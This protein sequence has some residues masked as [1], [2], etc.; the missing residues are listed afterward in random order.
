MSV[1]P[2]PS[3]SIGNA[4]RQMN[5]KRPGWLR[6]GLSAA[7]VL[8]T[9]LGIHN[10]GGTHSIGDVMA[11]SALGIPALVAG[12]KSLTGRRGSSTLG[13]ALLGAAGGCAANAV[14]AYSGSIVWGVAVTVLSALIGYGVQGNKW[15]ALDREREIRE[16]ADRRAREH[17][18]HK[19][20]LAAQKS[21][22]QIT[23]AALGVE[24]IRALNHSTASAEAQAS[25]ISADLVR[26]GLIQSTT[27][28]LGS[29][30]EFDKAVKDALSVSQPNVPEY[31]PEEWTRHEQ[32][33]EW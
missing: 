1:E 18:E 15:D 32:R 10:S 27:P 13:G 5:S 24:A 21:H 23:V 33:G 14:T 3:Q 30:G 7:A 2:S 25:A 16:A 26:R 9:G 4:F 22:T 6:P 20:R 31:V 12:T 17:E 11:W 28:Q 8:C 29:G 19:E